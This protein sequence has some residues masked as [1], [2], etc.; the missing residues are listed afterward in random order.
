MFSELIVFQADMQFFFADMPLFAGDMY[1][2]ALA[3][4]TSL[5]CSLPL[6]PKNG[7]FAQMWHICYEKLLIV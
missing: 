1:S 5:L 3:L 2:F 7:I 6:S 4:P